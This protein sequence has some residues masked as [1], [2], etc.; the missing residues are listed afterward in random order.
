M[1]DPDAQSRQSQ[2]DSF[3]RYAAIGTV[4]FIVWFIASLFLGAGHP[5]APG[6]MLLRFGLLGLPA[7]G[8]G[9]SIFQLYRLRTSD[10]FVASLWGAGTSAAFIA[11]LVLSVLIG[12][13][14]GVARDLELLAQSPQTVL[15]RIEPFVTDAGL[16][17]FF[18]A[19]QIKRLRSF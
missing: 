8:L 5:A 7:V 17:A 3:L 14:V 16:M 13:A 15:A 10:E 1:F 11:V 6:G 12:I 19:L 18:A 9:I 2:V 4:S